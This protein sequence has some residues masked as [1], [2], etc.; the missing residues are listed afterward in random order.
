MELRLNVLGAL[1]LGTVVTATAAGAQEPFTPVPVAPPCN[2]SINRGAQQALDTYM[3]GIKEQQ[4]SKKFELDRRYLQIR[5]SGNSTAGIEL[6][7]RL[8][9]QRQR[10]DEKMAYIDK[11]A[12]LKR[13]ALK[14]YKCEL[15]LFYAVP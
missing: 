1:A 14:K 2:A 5:G 7:Q 4:Q 6:E 10:Y 3:A 12:E 15:L 9:E 8:V 13:F 11:D